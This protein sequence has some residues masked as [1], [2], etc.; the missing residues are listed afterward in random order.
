MQRVRQAR[1]QHEAR[2]PRRACLGRTPAP[3][4]HQKLPPHVVAAAA[5][6]VSPSPGLA[7]AQPQSD[8]AVE[9]AGAARQGLVGFQPHAH[10]THGG[11]HPAAPSYRGPPAEAR[12]DAA[13]HRARARARRRRRR[14]QGR[15]EP[16]RFSAG[17]RALGPRRPARA[18]HQH[19]RPRRA[20]EADLDAAD[21]VQNPAA[22][23]VLRHGRGRVFTREHATKFWRAPA[24]RGRGRSAV[25]PRLR[26]R[27]R[28]R[29]L[30]H[31]L[32]GARRPRRAAGGAR[33][34]I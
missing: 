33:V 17:L 32:F 11:Q 7:R 18:A 26:Q 23:R 20:I 9:Q 34:D 3:V 27:Q 16:Q 19:G 28:R 5:A 24:G 13:V 10:G 29:A 8:D 4:V 22:R 12:R 25:P 21:A 6:P 31:E 14:A 30:R 1:R 15:L 2:G